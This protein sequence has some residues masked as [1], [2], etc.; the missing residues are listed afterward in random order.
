MEIKNQEPPPEKN[1]IDVSKLFKKHREELEEAGKS[2]LDYLGDDFNDRMGGKIDYAG[3]V[4]RR[5]EFYHLP[6]EEK[7]F[8]TALPPTSEAFNY[9]F[10]P[11]V[12]AAH[13]AEDIMLDKGREGLELAKKKIA[14]VRALPSNWEP[15][16]ATD[17]IAKAKHQFMNYEETEFTAPEV[18]ALRDWFGSSPIG[19]EIVKKL[20]SRLEEMQKEGLDTIE[21]TP[22]DFRI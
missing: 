3:R 18:E 14:K 12:Q 1:D 10:N 6:E 17:A 16:K 22:D 9:R 8:V 13:F 20:Q 2:L 15:P 21:L 11:T 7:M 5:G 19:D 4:V